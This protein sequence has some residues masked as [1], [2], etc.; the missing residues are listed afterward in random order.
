MDAATIAAG[1]EGVWFI[2]G[3]DTL[4]VTPIDPRTNRAGRSIRLGAQNLSAVAVGG[5][6]V[7]ASAEGDGLVWRIEP[8]PRPVS[9]T[10]DVGVGVTFLAYDDGAIWTANYHDGTV[11]RIDVKTDDVDA[12]P[13]GAVQGAGGRRRVG[14]GE[15]RGG[16]LGGRAPRDVRRAARAGRRAR[17]ADRV[18]PAA[19]GRPGRT[20]ARAG[21]RDP[22]RARA[23]RLQGR[24]VRRG[25]SLLRRLDRADGRLRPPHV[26]RERERLR[27]R[28]GAGGGDRPLQLG[29][30]PGRDPD[31]QPGAGRA[32]GA[33]QPLEHRSRPDADRRAP[34][35]GLPRRAGRLL[36]DRRAQ[37]RPPPGA[38]RHGRRRAGA[39]RKAARARERVRARRRDRSFWRFTAVEPVPLRGAQAGRGP[40]RLGRLPT[41]GEG[42]RGDRG[43]DR[44]LGRRRPRARGRP[45]H[46]RRPAAGGAAR[47]ARLALPDHGRLLLRRGRS[48][49][50]RADRRRRPRPVRGQLRTVSRR[51]RPDPGGAAVHGRRSALPATASCSRPRRRPSS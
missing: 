31:P 39:A 50:A 3:D 32:A 43:A 5:G 30:R 38:R 18:G 42:L 12:T 7:W 20:G 4:S 41:R 9:K 6:Y 22:A 44:A 8:G 46:R 10:I 26:R 16:D 27:A 14:L 51:D 35:L 49:D 47:A 36:P 40:R 29:L 28:E 25:L 24:E 17:R 23:A 48:R 45:L 13:V 21:R 34:A 37:L 1:R 11:S 19:P 2:S 15:H 33:D